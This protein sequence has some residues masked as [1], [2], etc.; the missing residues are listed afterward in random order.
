MRH[1]AVAAGVLT[2]LVATVLASRRADDAGPSVPNVVTSTIPPARTSARVVSV[3]LDLSA[4]PYDVSLPKGGTVE[5]R[6]LTVLHAPSGQV[7]FLGGEQ[8]HYVEDGDIEPVA[9]ADRSGRRYSIDAIRVHSKLES[10]IVGVV[11]VER[12]TRVVRWRQLQRVAYGTDAGLGGVTTVEWAKRPKELDNSLSRLYQRKLVHEGRRWL[13]ADVDGVPGVDTVLFDNGF[14]D[15]G[16]PSIA[17]YD[18]AGRR[19]QIVLWTIAAP[20][21]LAFPEGALPAHV[22]ARERALAACLAG[23]RTVDGGARCRRAG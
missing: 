7:L 11:F 13:A 23:T 16:F 3:T 20:W 10:R 15:G 4:R 14:G 1:L 6:K 9:L 22:T 5:R 12:P 19:A 8:A 18:A 17:G 2:V 21:R